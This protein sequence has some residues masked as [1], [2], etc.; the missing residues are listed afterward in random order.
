ML[1]RFTQDF[2]P[3]IC[4]ARC[5]ASSIVEFISCK[6]PFIGNDPILDR[7]Y[8]IAVALN[9]IADHLECDDNS[10]PQQNEYLLEN[11]KNIISKDVCNVSKFN[12]KCDCCA[13]LPEPV[14]LN[15]FTK[16]TPIVGDESPTN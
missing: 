10:N 7:S 15:A 6:E 2:E 9:A 3:F 12:C 8:A 1:I 11:L 14:D 5:Y 4:D 13:T 16:I